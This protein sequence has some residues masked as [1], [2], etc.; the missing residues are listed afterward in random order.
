MRANDAAS[1]REL[2]GRMAD[3]FL[4][5]AVATGCEYRV[6]ATEPPYDE[7]AP[8][9]WLADTFRAEM[10]RLGGPGRKGRGGGDAAGQHRYGECHP[11][12]AG[13]PPIVG[14]DAN[15]ASVHQPR[16]PQRRPAQRRQAVVEGAI[17]LARTVVRLAETAPSGPGAGTAGEGGAS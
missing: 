15:G 5:G 1:L 11:G 13:N 10:V 2:E 6:R 12:D 4:A 9:Q 17:M 3:C 16:S 8:D 14:I 7:L